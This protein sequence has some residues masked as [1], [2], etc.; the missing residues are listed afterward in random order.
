MRSS[1]RTQRGSSGIEN[2]RDSVTKQN[3]FSETPDELTKSMS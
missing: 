3:Q 2:S 1:D